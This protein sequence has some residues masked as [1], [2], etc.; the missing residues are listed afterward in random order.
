MT[1]RWGLSRNRLIQKSKYHT[2]MDAVLLPNNLPVRT[3]D[4]STGRHG[5][6]NLIR[7]VRFV[8]P[9][10]FLAIGRD[11]AQ[12]HPRIQAMEHNRLESSPHRLNDN[13]VGVVVVSDFLYAMKQNPNFYPLVSAAA[14]FASRMTLAR[15]GGC[16]P[17][18][19]YICHVIRNAGA[20][21][22]TH[23]EVVSPIVGGAGEIFV[24][25]FHILAWTSGEGR[26]QV[27]DSAQISNGM[28]CA[29]SEVAKRKRKTEL[30]MRKYS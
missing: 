3:N 17:E 25:A 21:R 22:I 10:Q 11:E 27:V 24:P 14:G 15:V 28:G 16:S 8:P 20:L 4:P 26:V 29:D 13:G 7:A 30:R 19:R 1:S 9:F 6:D 18:S 2:D 23:K 5:I 12:H